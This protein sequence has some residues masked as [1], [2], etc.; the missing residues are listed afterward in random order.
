[1]GLSKT[2]VFTERVKLQ[3]RAE[4]FN[5]FNRVNF[6]EC[7]ITGGTSLTGASCNNNFIKTGSKPNFGALQQTLDP[8]IGQLGLKLLF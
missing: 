1:M 7:Q 4:F 5:V 2:F 6:D 3:F 8:R